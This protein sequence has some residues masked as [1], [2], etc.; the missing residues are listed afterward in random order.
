MFL[1]FLASLVFSINFHSWVYLLSWLCSPFWLLFCFFLL[2]FPLFFLFF[3]FVC[4]C[5]FGCSEL[6]SVVI[7]TL[8]VLSSVCSVASWSPGY[9]K[10][11]HMN[12]WGR[13]TGSRIVN[14]QRTLVPMEHKLRTVL[15]KASISTLGPSLPNSYW[16][17]S[18][19]DTAHQTFSKNK[20]G[21]QPCQLEGRLPKDTK[22]H[23]L[24]MV[25]PFR[26]TRSSSTTRTQ[27]TS[28]H[29]HETF[30]RHWSKSTHR[31]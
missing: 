13:R 18:V 9:S 24:N 29:N 30:T 4:V 19:S 23:Y 16:A 25:L 15:L 7:I 8:V 3:S 21:T 2:I 26:E 5:F 17:P 31:R 27:K 28:S 1:S 12:H 22:T 14:H 20:I 6:L 11:S 10:G